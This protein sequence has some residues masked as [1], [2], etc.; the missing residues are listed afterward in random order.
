M[1]SL[2][3]SAA[4]KGIEIHSLKCEYRTNP[5]SVDVLA[6]R[7]SW[8]IQAEERA[9]K[10]SKYQ[11]LVA[12]DPKL[13]TKNIGD[14]WDTG[15]VVSDV[16]TH[17]P[18]SGKKLVSGQMC[19]W[20]VRMW[21]QNGRSSGWSKP[22]S[23]SMG[24][25]QPSD[26][27]AQWI[28]LDGGEN[29]DTFAQ[30]QWMWLADDTAKVGANRCFRRS[31]MIPADRELIGARITIGTHSTFSVS[32]NG[33]SICNGARTIFTPASE[34]DVESYLKP[35]LNAIAIEASCCD[36]NVEPSGIICALSAEFDTGAP[37]LVTSNSEWKVSKRRMAGWDMPD[38]DDSKWVS[39]KEFGTND[40]APFNRVQGDD[41]RR[42]SAR[43]LRR[44]FDV[45]KKLTRATAY[46]CGLGLSELYL[47]GRK[48]GDHVLSPGLTDYNKRS[49][50]VTYDVTK[51]IKQG[52]NAVGVILGNGR[53]FAPRNS[54]PTTTFS[55]GYP[56]LL[57]QM[58]MEYDDGS[59]DTVVS[60][61]S[62]KLTTD[63]PILANNEYDGE[64]YDA[65][66]EMPG[67]N[68]AGFDSS[69]WQPAQ[70]VEA[71]KGIMCSEIAE[72]IKV[73]D[74]V[75][76]IAITSPRPGVYIFDMGQNMVG[77]CKLKV[78]GP[79]GT[80]V[81]MQHAE[82]L[83]HNG[84][85]YLEN[86]RSAKVT[87]RYT[88]KGTGTEV[89][90]PRFTYHGF[91]FV[92]VSGYPGKPDLS[93]IEGVVIHDSM[94][95]VG[96]F[97]CSNPLVNKIYHN[98]YW[99]I[100]G[101]YRSIPT[102]CPQR[103]ERQGWFGDRAQV[104]RGE[105]YVFD[106]AAMHTKWMTDIRDSQKE[107]GSIPDL[108]PAYWAFYTNSVT[109]PTLAFSIPGHLYRAYGDKQILEHQYDAIK[110]WTDMMRVKL[111]GDI[112]PP[113]TYGDWCVPPES[114]EMIWSNDAMRVTDKELVASAYFYYNL[115]QL[116]Y[117]ASVLGNDADVKLYGEIAAR[118]KVAFNAKWL[119]PVEGVYDNGNQTS[120]ILPLAFGLVPDANRKQIV[121]HLVSKILV[122]AKGHVGTGMI[123]CQWLMRVLTDNGWPDVAHRL[124]TNT[125][126]PSWG[127]MIKKGATT[128]WELWNGD[129]G[130]PLMDSGNHV[131]QIGDLCTWLYEY[132]AGIAPDDN[133]PG[134]KHT[135]MRPV[136]TDY[137]TSAKATHMSMYGLISS[138]WKI[139]R[140]V[141]S[142]AIEVP[143]NTTA[144][145][146]VPTTD[147][148]GIT[149]SGRLAVESPGVRLVKD[150]GG[151][152]QFE[153]GSGRYAFKS[154]VARE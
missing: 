59:R 84:E 25:L 13:L 90:E 135:I 6:P 10:Q 149:E 8:S 33:Q 121:D 81:Y 130:D 76:P 141:F 119:K 69:A 30:A 83:Q 128:I 1:S 127:Y 91:R 40:H 55:Y 150:E 108:A 143:A 120:C 60:D 18:Y 104:S 44:D 148:A 36:P 105:M 41:Y 12:S 51:N 68:T 79:R 144:T 2:S 139:S 132:V 97:E 26:W 46:I 131:M 61:A 154:T 89:Y 86:L 42:L 114:R 115:Q 71:P 136:M 15:E 92:E 49:L 103:D 14:L 53:Y 82:K 74:T 23:W 85:L 138:D 113:D 94:A 78:K 95:E 16:C 152:V 19:Y 39:V 66:K 101:N 62:W 45:P 153:L 28:G 47:N 58:E 137:F 142:W 17:L 67:W 100:R 9:V 52:A 80:K 37:M 50:Y 146:Y 125:T 38:F 21:D 147:A 3:V 93:A 122:D 32:I 56:K 124:A 87:D 129:T 11:I 4:P 75:N 48:V 70:L 112:M 65:R 57:L 111:N 134:F 118:M 35:G 31:V 109:F 102:D 27:K 133:V 117:F 24:L 106:T 110:R 64:V 126:Y 20:K 72:P 77:W 5:L 88:L 145:I 151:V 116:A 43:M 54:A 29:P 73:M 99:G 140:G 96:S 98:I 107:D 22:A 123:G 63:G 7:L 34:I